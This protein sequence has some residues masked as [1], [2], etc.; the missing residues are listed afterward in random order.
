[1]SASNSGVSTSNTPES[2]SDTQVSKQVKRVTGLVIDGIDG[3]PLIGANIIVKGTFVGTVSDINGKFTLNV[4]EKKDTLIISFLGYNTL[5][6]GIDGKDYI[7]A[8]LN[9]RQIV[10]EDVVVIGYG[11]TTKKNLTGS[12]SQVTSEKLTQVTVSNPTDLLAGRVPG[13]ITKS[14]T[15]L[16]GQGGS[17]L[18]IR[19]YSDPLI[20]VDGIQMDFSSIDPNDIASISVLKDASAAIYGA[21]AGNGVILVT[22]KRGE[23]GNARIKI[24]SDVS[25]QAPTQLITPVNAAQFAEMWREGQ[26]NSGV[27]ETFTL[28]EIRKYQIDTA[29]YHSYNWYDA[30]FREWAP[31]QSFNASVSGG[32][33]DIS[34][35][36]SVGQLNQESAFKSGDYNYS[37]YNIRS[38]LDAK[39]NKYLG[40]Y[41]NLSVRTENTDRTTANLDDVFGGLMR[42]QPRYNPINPDGS[43]SYAGF[44]G[45]SPAALSNSKYSGITEENQDRIE[46]AIGSKLTVPS[47]EGM[48][49][50]ARL[51]FRYTGS[52]SWISSKQFEVFEYIPEIDDYVVRGAN[53]LN[54]VSRNEYQDRWLNPTVSL[55]YDRAFEN[56]RIS[57]LALAE[58]ITSERKGFSA[59][60]LNPIS[61][62]LPYLFA[63][64][65]EA[66]DNNDS[67][68]ES[69]RM[70]YVG[71]AQYSYQNR[72]RLEA[73]LRADA[74]HKF[75]PDSRWGYF[76]SISGSWSINNEPFFKVDA[77]DELRL[78]VSYSKTGQDDGVAAFRYM[79]E[80]FIRDDYFMFGDVIQ[81]II[82]EQGLPNPNVTWLEMTSYNIG[83]NVGLFNGILDAEF[84]LF[85]RLTDNIFGTSLDQF[86]STFGATLPPLN[87]NARENNGFELELNHTRRL[88][89]FKY[90]VGGNLAYSREKYVR[91]AEP[92][93][94]DEDEARL[95][96][97]EGNYVNRYIGYK[98]DGI[99]MSQEEI[100]NYAV[101]QDGLG[102]ST[103]RPGDVKYKDLNGD[104]EVNFRDQTDI[105]RGAFPDMSFGFNVDLEY[106]GLSVS[107]LFQGASMFNLDVV[108]RSRGAFDNEGV[109][110][111]YQYEY[112]W[113]PD[114]DNPS[115]NINPNAQLPAIT[116]PGVGANINNSLSS[117]FWLQDGTYLRLKNLNISYRI[118]QQFVQRVGIHSLSLFVSGTNLMTWDR[119][120][121]YSGSFD[122]EIPTTTRGAYPTIKTI[123]FGFN[124]EI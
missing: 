95:F 52:S 94:E 99:F 87:I 35:F 55:R 69:A 38:N 37:R 59:S 92:E 30:A 98:S 32:S 58:Y 49:A 47:I 121:I 6:V 97:R 89:D 83:L 85:S 116:N 78:R 77:I 110:H 100:D 13:L 27:N 80:Y 3:L 106:K 19:G 50:E 22:T 31:M 4:P 24:R 17:S 81:R 111:F 101:N 14:N 61:P 76:P 104:G 46:G 74:T 118:P 65:A 91:W 29:G 45:V 2:G 93:Y 20:L 82:R 67:W 34:Y 48:E 86:P 51:N 57:G 15:G 10:G 42:A 23:S 119:L 62:D 40:A 90:S 60:R 63:S 102:N 96:K 18:R 124:L 56:H 123:T 41:V 9:P 113:Q 109:P 33:K 108:G 5:E 1:M 84:N 7:K 26:I 21:R 8:T 36:L 11:T 28:D 112:R 103:L 66:I 70:S 88:G 64:D 71:R 114:P 53:G 25:Y 122:P 39:V 105:G 115:V 54:R 68:T 73:T 117:D 44:G 107:A 12:V 72:Y 43:P 16:P 79:S 120:G 75:S